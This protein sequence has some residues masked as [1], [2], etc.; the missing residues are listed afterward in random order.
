MIDT[1]AAP[2]LIE[3]NYLQ[4]EQAIR[5]DSAIFLS[6]ISDNKIKILETT[7]VEYQRHTITLHVVKNEFPI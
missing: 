5:T 6:G 3:R 1:S 4:S 2:N 7:D